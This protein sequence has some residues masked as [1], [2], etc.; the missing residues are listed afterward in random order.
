MSS[1]STNSAVIPLIKQKLRRCLC[2]GTTPTP[3]PPDI[4]SI[5]NTPMNDAKTHPVWVGFTHY[6]NTYYEHQVSLRDYCCLDMNWLAT[7]CT[8]RPYIHCQIVFWNAVSGKYYT[9][10]V[11]Y[12]HNV[13]VYDEKEFKRGWTWV[14]LNVTERAELA[15]HNF[16]VDQLGKPMSA[17]GQYMA[18]TW[19]PAAGN[20]TRWFCSELIARALIEGGIICDNNVQP[21]AMAPHHLLDYLLMECAYLPRPQEQHQNPVSLL[22][23][24]RLAHEHQIEIDI[25]HEG[26]GQ[27]IASAVAERQRSTS[28]GKP[29]VSASASTTRRATSSWLPA[30]MPKASRQH[31]STSSSKREIELV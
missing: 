28:S 9:F 14:R 25:P 31:E 18:L 5:K 15:M 17:L 30:T 19:F 1:S 21:E 11:D 3:N 20:D 7:F 26:I 4:H 23:V 29:A 27:S 2:R 16:L 10:S 13:H 24:Q 12:E 8:R 6:D 22:A